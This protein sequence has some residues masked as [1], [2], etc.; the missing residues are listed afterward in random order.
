MNKS[1]EIVFFPGFYGS[2]FD[3]VDNEYSSLKYEIEYYKDTYNKEFTMDDFN[4]AVLSIV[5]AVFYIV[6]CLIAIAVPFF[7]LTKKEET[8]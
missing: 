5:S 8:K 2:I 1:L 3:P 6:T 7:G 4:S